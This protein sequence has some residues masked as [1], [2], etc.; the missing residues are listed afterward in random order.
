MEIKCVFLQHSNKTRTE[1]C[2]LCPKAFF[3]KRDLR[4]HLRH[5]HEKIPRNDRIKKD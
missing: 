2:E 3:Q 5:V 1:K 4:R